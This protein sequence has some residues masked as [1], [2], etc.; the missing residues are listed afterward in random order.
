MLGKPPEYCI[1]RDNPKLR[2]MMRYA[3]EHCNKTETCKAARV[4]IRNFYRFMRG[5][6]KEISQL[7]TLR[8][9]DQLKIKVTLDCQ[10]A[11]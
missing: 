9:C 8:M 1:L 6:S 3:W 7:E 4:D 2:K 5:E 11:L 10:I